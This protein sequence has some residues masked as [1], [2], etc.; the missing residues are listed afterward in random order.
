MSRLSTLTRA[1]REVEALWL[2]DAMT[3]GDFFVEFQ[4][5]FD[6]RTG[7][8]L[9][10]EGLLR[11]RSAGGDARLAAEIF[12][13]AEALGLERQFERF[14]WSVVLDSVRRLPDSA[15]LFLNVN[16]RLLSRSENALAGLGEETERRGV[17]F[18]RLVLDLVEVE[19]MPGATEI[20]TALTVPRDL[21]A[22]VALD[23]VTSGYGTLQLCQGLQPEYIKVDSEITR[24]IAQDPRRRAILKFVADLG[25]EFSFLLVA[26]GI[27]SSDDLDV[28]ATEGVAAAQGYFLAR[29]AAEPPAAS[30]D[31]REWVATRPDFRRP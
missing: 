24:G 13:A 16:P 21:G 1:R 18:S 29:P 15:L 9:G 5:I 10:Y 6:L 31:M 20:S 7:D 14:A 17:S 4:P 30:G 8:V 25:R 23:D 19:R 12:P 3:G 28:C 26:E 2:G 22:A 11:A 27:E